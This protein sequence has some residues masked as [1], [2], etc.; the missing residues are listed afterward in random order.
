M[1]IRKL[2]IGIVLFFAV[3]VIGYSQDLI[4]VFSRNY[5][6]FIIPKEHY[7]WGIP[8]EKNRY[9]LS[10]DE[11]QQIEDV[12]QKNIQ[13]ICYKILHRKHSKYYSKRFLKNYVRQY[14]ANISEDGHII[15]SIHL[16]MINKSD[17]KRDI[18]DKFWQRYKEDLV[19]VYDGGYEV[20][21]I[22]MDFTTKKL[23]ELHT[24]STIIW[25]KPQF[26]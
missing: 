17:I 3:N 13:K 6:G 4:P 25:G 9:T 11:V 20:C 24:N 26:D 21:R 22:Y 23:L 2:I 5:K 8:P 19:A 7:T 15:I 10:K 18:N 14:F 16:F 12:F 1:N